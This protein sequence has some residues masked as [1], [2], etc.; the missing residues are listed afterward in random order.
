MKLSYVHQ[1]VKNLKAA[2]AFYRDTLGLEEAW[3]EGDFVAALK[4]PGTEVQLLLDQDPN[5]EAAGP[6]F[7]IESVDAFYREHKG[8]VHFLFEP[9][10]IPPGR[11]SAF[12]DDSGNI[13]RL[14]D[15]S[16]E[17]RH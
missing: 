17:Q 4:L 16:R 3:R 10:D 13:V 12:K 5:E 6:T 7:A 15:A 14:I 9:R 1:P 2:L 8:K 11:Y